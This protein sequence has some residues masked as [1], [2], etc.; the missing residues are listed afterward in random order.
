LTTAGAFS[1][2]QILLALPLAMNGR[3]IMEP[4]IDFL[5]ITPLREERDAIL[6]RLQARRVPPSRK[7]VRVY[8][9]AK[10]PIKLADRTA[11]S[12]NII[13]AS[14]LGLGRLEAATATS[15]AIHRWQPRHVLLVGIAGG[16]QKAGV[17]LGDVL[18]SDTV[19]DYELQKL[20]EVAEIRW[21]VHRVDPQLLGAAQNVLD[22]SWMNLVQVRRPL[23]G[24]PRLHFGP[25]CTGDKVIANSLLDKYREVWTRLIG[26]EMEAGGVAS[27]AFQAPSRPGFFMIRGVSDLADKKKDTATVGK[28]R[29]YACDVAASFTVALLRQGPIL[30]AQAPVRVKSRRGA[31]S[32]PRSRWQSASQLSVGSSR[33]FWRPAPDGSSRFHERSAGADPTILIILVHGTAGESVNERST[34]SRSLLKAIGSDLDVISY[35]CTGA[36]SPQSSIA[37][38][39][40]HLKQVILSRAQPYMHLFF[41]AHDEGGAVVKE[42]I[43]ADVE[44][45]IARVPPVLA[46]LPPIAAKVRAVFDSPVTPHRAALPFPQAEDLVGKLRE[47][48]VRSMDVLK[49]ND[50]PRPRFVEFLVAGASGMLSKGLPGHDDLAEVIRERGPTRSVPVLSTHNRDRIAP[51]AALVRRY[52]LSPEMMMSY[53]VLRRVVSLD[54]GT[55]PTS[56]SL[57]D[58]S[59]STSAHS[60]W[61]GWYGSQEFVLQRLRELSD[62]RQ[63]REHAQIVI[64][65]GAGIGK[66]TVLR[67]HARYVTSRYLEGHTDAQLCIF[68][69]MQSVT[70]APTQLAS[71]PPVGTAAAGWRVL[72]KYTA[73]LVAEI[74]LDPQ[75]ETAFDS[76]TAPRSLDAWQGVSALLTPA[77]VEGRVLTGQTKI[78]LDGL[79]EFLVNHSTLPVDALA[80]WL[81]LFAQSSQRARTQCLLAVRNTLPGASELLRHRDDAYEIR[82]LSARAAEKMFPGT[83]ILLKEMPDDNLR[84]LLLTPLVLVRLGPRASFMQQG[85]LNT[86]AAILRQALEAIIAESQLLQING[87]SIGGKRPDSWLQAL[88]LVAW[89]LYRDSRG[90]ITLSDLRVATQKLKALWA[91][92]A[93]PMSHRFA[94][95]FLILE[96]DSTLKA[97][98]SRT[99]LNNL[100][101]EAVRF[102]HQEWEDFLVAD[103]LAHA[104]LGQVFSEFAHRAFAKQI[105]IDAANVL[106]EE[107]AGLGAR[108]DS[109]WLGNVLAESQ[110]CAQPYVLMNC[111][112]LLGNGPVD[113]DQMAFRR[114]RDSV[115]D[116]DCPEVTR[117]VAVSSFCM[118]ALRKDDRDRSLRYMIGDMV[119]MLDEIV[120]Q[121]AGRERRVSAS[122]A[123]CYRAEISRKYTLRLGAHEQWPAL[124]AATED[125]IAAAGASGIVWQQGD[126]S[127][128]VD[129]RHT[130]F[131]IAAAQYPLAVREIP[132]EEV[133]LTHY[134]FL[135]SAALGAGVATSEM[136]PLLREVFS[137]KSGVIE[138]VAR[139]GLAE[140]QKLFTSCHEAAKSQLEAGAAAEPFTSVAH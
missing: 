28:W 110:A 95:G 10:L 51:I 104:A 43:A 135:A 61:A 114:L 129:A 48:L 35:D 94:E 99:V 67:R 22:D 46:R 39:A 56:A 132:N 121:G 59:E 82:H 71:F 116:A 2:D 69:S 84:R 105:Y 47:R 50:F 31:R 1:L 101:R 75:E 20:A 83:R 77:W 64:T 32:V 90:F 8:F 85:L 106:W 130:S 17:R 103:Y 127:K 79:D 16:Y 45:A 138:R 78:I 63:V 57:E 137:Q 44:S 12:Y 41:L 21:S 70:F 118:R 92:G 76:P 102:A 120:R 38:A 65:G 53:L 42:L 40:A 52:L 117:L 6:R 66:S 96:T 87:A 72:S 30:P 74:L 24:N 122:M 93:H 54:G 98:R 27:V 133:S 107:M 11:V 112:A 125:G 29:Q 25:I 14:L 139:C 37:D 100:G 89:A 26:V 49:A 5:I 134:L 88:A 126:A 15:D 55:T 18:I 86:R 124:S 3:E 123:W 109:R 136:I 9:R 62:G 4:P 68:I 115:C 97:L 111:C 81:D 7:D 23:K 73:S 119:D 36:G 33:T 34:F 13:V 113:I 80:R 60:D 140:V 128:F 108:I 131:Q 91:Q 58:T 19:A